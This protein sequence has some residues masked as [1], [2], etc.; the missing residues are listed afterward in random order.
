MLSKRWQDVRLWA[1]RQP[2][3][4]FWLYV[5]V[6]VFATVI[7]LLC[8][9]SIGIFNYVKSGQLKDLLIEWYGAIAYFLKQE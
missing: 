9:W 8:Q 2:E 3:G 5:W 1:D 7:G 4:S 6:L